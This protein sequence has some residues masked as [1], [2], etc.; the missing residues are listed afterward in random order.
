[1][2]PWTLNTQIDDLANHIKDSFEKCEGLNSL[3]KYFSLISTAQPIKEGDTNSKIDFL[4]RQFELLKE[5]INTSNEPHF[6]GMGTLSDI[7]IVDPTN[8]SDDMNKQSEDYRIHKL[9]DIVRKI[10]SP[11]DIVAFKNSYP[12]IQFTFSGSPN[13]TIINQVRDVTKKFGYE[14]FSYR[15]I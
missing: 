13:Q 9:V 8:P 14:E 6:R 5:R 11:V 12:R 15:S 2:N 3:W 7:I 10:I 4:I 1:M